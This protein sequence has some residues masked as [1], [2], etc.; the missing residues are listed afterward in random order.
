M[1]TQIFDGVPKPGYNLLENHTLNIQ[2]PK[3]FHHFAVKKKK[4]LDTQQQKKKARYQFNS[5]CLWCMG[6]NSPLQN[7]DPLLDSSPLPPTHYSGILATC[8]GQH[9]SKEPA[10]TH[11]LVNSNRRLFIGFSDSQSRDLRTIISRSDPY[12]EQ[13]DLVKGK[14]QCDRKLKTSKYSNAD[15]AYDLIFKNFPLFSL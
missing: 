10:C 5:I 15:N 11:T 4:I 1:Y 9:F 14:F 6:S 12:T 13:K 7:V 2:P 8:P 3:F